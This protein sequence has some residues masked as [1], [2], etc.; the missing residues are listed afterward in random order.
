MSIF[1]L[2]SFFLHIYIYLLLSEKIFDTNLLKRYSNRETSNDIFDRYETELKK[3]LKLTD[4][5]EW[6][7]WGALYYVGTVYTTIGYGNI[8]PHTVLGKFFT[9]IYALVGIPLV[10]AILS[11]SGQTLSRYRFGSTKSKN[12]KNV[13][14]RRSLFDTAPRNPRTIPIWVALVICFAWICSCAGIFCIWEKNWTYY[15]SLYFFFVSLSTIGLGDVVPEH[16]HI[17]IVMFLLVIAGLSLVSMLLS[18][19]QIKIEEFLLRLALKLR[20]LFILYISNTARTF[21]KLYFE[22]SP[23][24]IQFFCT[25]CQGPKL[26]RSTA[27]GGGSIR[28]PK[29]TLVDESQ[30]FDAQDAVDHSVQ[31]D[32]AQFEL[33]EIKLK[34][35][36][37]QQYLRIIRRFLSNIND[38][39][40]QD[41]IVQ[42]DDSYLKIARRLEEIRSIKTAGLP[43]YAADPK[44]VS[45]SVNFDEVLNLK[46]FFR[47]M[48]K[49]LPV[50]NRVPK[51]R[52]EANSS[53]VEN[54][55]NGR[56]REVRNAS[57]R[58]QN[59]FL[60]TSPN[61][62]PNV[63][64]YFISFLTKYVK[65]STY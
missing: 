23:T 11:Q 14:K 55:E 58:Q 30:Q 41:L 53:V 49:S 60:S 7:L 43:V 64:L 21:F 39:L 19:L 26:L 8:Y 63:S 45:T 52:R 51:K 5:L 40:V 33:D 29:I 57:N 6:D 48:N 46:T 65:Y 36:N 22:C 61:S 56:T 44:L 28:K 17:L 38:K 31:T 47:M 20:V 18:I 35:L 12:V 13:L 62:N 25:T 1:F 59:L 34:L 32:I 50:K 3:I 27:V 9:V 37:L 24:K 16:P 42:T 15:D 4:N 2:S 10:L 54:K